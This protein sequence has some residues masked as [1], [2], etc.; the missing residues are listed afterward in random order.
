MSSPNQTSAQVGDLG[1]FKPERAYRKHPSR[2]GQVGDLGLSFPTTLE[3]RGATAN[4]GQA[5]DLGFLGAIHKRGPWGC[6]APACLQS[7]AYL[8]GTSDGNAAFASSNYAPAFA[9]ASAPAPA[10]SA[11]ARTATGISAANLKRQTAQRISTAAAHASGA[12]LRGT[13]SRQQKHQPA[14]RTQPAPAP[15]A[16]A[17]P[18]PLAH[19]A[20]DPAMLRKLVE[21]RVLSRQ[22]R[23]AAAATTTG[24][25]GL[26]GLLNQVQPVAAPVI[27]LTP[28]GEPASLL[29]ASTPVAPL[30]A[31]A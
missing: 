19:S 25:A 26:T 6:D 27:S 10:Y 3:T 7:C 16:A 8:P 23:Q 21:A 14:A 31:T 29:A 11:A 1:F 5:G 9:R 12:V 24:V 22:Q 30:Q 15:A 4:Y 17:A 18:A 2:W 20:A 13:P 28:A